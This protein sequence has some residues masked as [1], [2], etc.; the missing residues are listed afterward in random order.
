MQRLYL[1]TLGYLALSALAPALAERTGSPLQPVVM[2]NGRVL[3]ELAVIPRYEPASIEIA[4]AVSQ[5]YRME[6]A[7]ASVGFEDSLRYNLER[8]EVTGYADY[9]ADRFL[10]QSRGIVWDIVGAYGLTTA[11]GLANWDW[12]SGSFKFE[13]EGWFGDDTRYGGM[14]KL[15]H[16]YS[17]YLLTEYF[18]QRIAHTTSDSAGA[19]LTGAI[20]GM[21]VQTYVEVFDGFSGGHGFSYEDLIMDGVGVGFSML[22]STVPGLAE[23][24]DFRMEYLPSGHGEGYSPASDYSGQKYLLALKLAGFEEFEDTPLRFVEFQVGYF[25]RGFS[26]EERDAGEDRRREPYVAIGVNLNELIGA[27]PVADTT[28]GLLAGRATEYLQ[29]PYTYVPTSAD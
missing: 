9:G 13:S 23:K 10:D 20:L 2:A 3:P 21:G 25:A 28:A 7:S 4:P 12:G 15:G 22:R 18:T 11:F 6:P 14:D 16:A 17:G 24:L 1:A 8:L 19:A 29:M 5:N 26:D 27:S